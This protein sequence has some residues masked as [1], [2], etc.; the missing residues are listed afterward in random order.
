MRLLSSDEERLSSPLEVISNWVV[1]GAITTSWPSAPDPTE[2][3]RPLKLS[4]LSV[5]A[6]VANV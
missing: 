3:L 2:K 5:A 1:A 6:Q 4:E